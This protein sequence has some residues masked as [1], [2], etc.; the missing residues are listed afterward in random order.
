MP[1]TQGLI[2]CV[3]RPKGKRGSLVF[4]LGFSGVCLRGG[5]GYPSTSLVLNRVLAETKERKKSKTQDH[6]IAFSFIIIPTFSS[7]QF[8]PEDRLMPTTLNT[9]VKAVGR[10]SSC[11]FANE[12]R[13]NFFETGG[14]LLRQFVEYAIALASILRTRLT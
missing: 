14:P 12:L 3:S 13:E 1:A 11:I 6:N 7:S 9:G 4:G 5:G 2:G 8:L 10:Q